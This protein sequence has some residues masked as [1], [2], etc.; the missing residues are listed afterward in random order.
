MIAVLATW[1]RATSPAVLPAERLFGALRADWRYS[2]SS[3]PL[4]AVLVRALAFFLGASA[5]M[6]LLPLIV[7]GD[8]VFLTVK[9]RIRSR[10]STT[11]FNPS[12]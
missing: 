9:R 11:R 2:R 7:R 12:G 3:W 10:S 4:Q 5:G 8:H 6:S 1:K